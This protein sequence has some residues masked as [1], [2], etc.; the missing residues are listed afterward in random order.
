MGS[1]G[2]SAVKS[3]PTN[4]GDT[5]TP[6]SGRYPGEGNSS[7]LQYSCLQ[8]SKDREAWLTTVCGVAKSWTWL[9]D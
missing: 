1:P 8:N 7:P 6:G 9:S 5:S 2:G 4:T 3:P